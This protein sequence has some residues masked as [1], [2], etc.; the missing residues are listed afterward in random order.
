MPVLQILNVG[1]VLEVLFERV[2]SLQ[3][4]PNWGDRGGIDDLVLR[5]IGHVWNISQKLYYGF[6]TER[7]LQ[8][9]SLHRRFERPRAKN[10]RDGEEA[11]LQINRELVSMMVDRAAAAHQTSPACV[12]PAAKDPCRGQPV[13][14]G[15]R[16]LSACDK[17]QGGRKRRLR[18]ARGAVPVGVSR[19][20]KTNH[21]LRRLPPCSQRMLIFARML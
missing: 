1:T 21:M 8:L 17:G 18:G 16:C 19:A 9:S 5:G 4:L 10:R 2:S 13:R 20:A 15:A 14:L 6:E 7:G 11:E 12:T 3:S